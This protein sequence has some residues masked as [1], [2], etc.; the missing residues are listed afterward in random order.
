MPV[1]RFTVYSLIGTVFWVVPLALAGEALGSNWKT[2]R[3]AFEWVDYVLLVLIVVGIVLPDR[4]PPAGT[5]APRHRCG[6]LSGRCRYDTPSPWACC[7]GPRS[8]CRSPPRRTPRCCRGSPAGATRSSTTSCARASRWPSTAARRRRSRCWRDG[9]WPPTRR[10]IWHSRPAVLVL[11]LAPPALAGLA[12]GR[13]HRTGPRRPR[14][15]RAGAR[16]GVGRDAGGRAARR[17]R[18]GGGRGLARPG[19]CGAGDGLALG[20]AQAVALIPGISRSGATIGAARWRGFARADAHR[21]SWTVALPVIAGAGL[22]QGLRLRRGGVP[23]GLRAG[24]G[25]PGPG[26][27]SARRSPPGRCCADAHAR[28]PADTVRALPRRAGRPGG[29]AR[30]RPPVAGK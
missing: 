22:L 30:G 2:A 29:A 8:C 15:D 1:V 24:D 5:Q 6:G 14:G 18:A 26:R 20:L 11:A 4:A 19:G 28:L 25:R 23:A 10:R 13:T 21:L 12:L 17:G 7:R 16:G 9:S 3:K 27:P